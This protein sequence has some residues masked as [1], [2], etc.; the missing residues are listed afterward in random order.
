[1]V[2]AVIT[3][4]YPKSRAGTAK[5]AGKAKLIG[6][7][8]IVEWISQESRPSKASSKFGI[9]VGMQVTGAKRRGDNFYEVRVPPDS[10]APGKY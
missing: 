9:R 7:D 3:E 5:L 10:T 6:S 1:M 2:R 8:E 4:L